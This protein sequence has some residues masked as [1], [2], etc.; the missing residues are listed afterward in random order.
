MDKTVV[1]L[2]SDY[3]KLNFN[4]ALE[5]DC[6]TYKAIVRDAFIDK[7]SKTEEGREYLQDCW[8]LTQ[9][10]PEKSKLR[11]QFKQE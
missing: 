8:V 7:M 3:T 11:Q 2:V 9:T 10:S 5:L 6:Y 1:K 4:Q